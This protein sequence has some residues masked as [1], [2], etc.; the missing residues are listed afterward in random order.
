M[1]RGIRGATTVAGDNKDEILKATEELMRKIEEQNGL[2][3]E[4]ISHVMITVTDDLTATFPARSLRDMPGYQF[5]PVMCAR[6]IPVP[7]SLPFCIRLM[8]TA[9]TDRGQKDVIHIYLNEAEKLRP[10]LSLT[11]GNRQR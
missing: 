6:E 7:G 5:V 9:E 3:P 11:K 2:S 4:H 8:V 1:I 10:D